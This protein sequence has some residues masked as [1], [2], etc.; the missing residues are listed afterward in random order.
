ME[1]QQ[2]EFC[3]GGPA[4]EADARELADF[5]AGE[6]P[7]WPTHVGPGRVVPT[8][9]GTRGDATTLA[10]I[11]LVLALPGS[12]KNAIDLADRLKLK[13]KLERLIDWAK[14]RRE[15]RLTNPSIA[16]PPH[17]A[18]VPLDQVKPEQV[19]QALDLLA[20]KPP[21]GS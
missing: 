10:I 16:L 1:K 9:P 3:F 13:T 8:A 2:F 20:P 12:I 19:L 15:R 18:S 11:A 21:R 6:F 14:A 17:G 4:A 5:L 7:D